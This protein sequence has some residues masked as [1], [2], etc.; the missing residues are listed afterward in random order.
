MDHRFPEIEECSMEDIRRCSLSFIVEVFFKNAID[1]N[2]IEG[3]SGGVV[4][5]KGGHRREEVG[6]RKE[7]PGENHGI[8]GPTFTPWGVVV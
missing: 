3:K 5:K 8:D 2:P 4:D 6:P 1:E 7:A